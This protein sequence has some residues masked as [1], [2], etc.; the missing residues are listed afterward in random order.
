MNYSTAVM[1]INK[2]IR[3]VKGQYDP[4]VATNRSVSIFKTLLQD[5]KVDDYVVVESGTR[6]GITT[7]KIT[8]L[9]CTVDFD[10]GTEVKWVVQKI[11]MDAHKKIT[12]M[13]KQA[14]DAIKKGEMRKRREDI[15]KNT[16]DAAAAGE[17]EG[18]D[19]AKLGAP[20]LE[21]PLGGKVPT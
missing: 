6:H 12:D 8:E 16:V 20:A 13:E 14:I 9:D 18:L 21:A 3:A 1:L 15:L 10:S 7:V 4:E 17:I 5:L 2:S 19:I 11:D